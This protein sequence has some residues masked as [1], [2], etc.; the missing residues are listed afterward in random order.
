[1]FFSLLQRGQGCPLWRREG[2]RLSFV[3]CRMDEEKESKRTNSEMTESQKPP[4]PEDATC[5]E[6]R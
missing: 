3:F 2:A 6:K 1:M 4:F 5:Y